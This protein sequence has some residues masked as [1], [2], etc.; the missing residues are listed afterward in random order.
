MPHRR[1]SIS[2]INSPPLLRGRFR[3]RYEELERRRAELMARLARLGENGR[4]HPGYNRVLKLLCHTFR[5]SKLPHRLAVL[6]AAAW[7]IDL[8]EQITM[9]M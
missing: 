5:R 4:G 6:Q 2:S 7:L 3:Q 1:S 9:T 8:L